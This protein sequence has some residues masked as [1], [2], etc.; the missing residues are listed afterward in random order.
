MVGFWEMLKRDQE[1]DTIVSLSLLELAVVTV[2]T[3]S[4]VLS[5]MVLMPIDIDISEVVVCVVGRLYRLSVFLGANI[6]HL[7]QCIMLLNV[8]C[9]SDTS[10]R[11]IVQ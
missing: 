5:D 7:V 10:R 8:T 2:R 6:L 3:S 1:Q 4:S 11:Q 9:S